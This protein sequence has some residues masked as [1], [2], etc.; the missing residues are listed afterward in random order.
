MAFQS[1]LPARG[2]TLFSI[3]FVGISAFQST[4][5]A[6]GATVKSVGNPSH[7][8][9]QS[10]LP[11]RG[12]TPHG[13]R[14]SNHPCYFNPRS[15]HG[16]RRCRGIRKAGNQAFQSTLPARGA[17]NPLQA[18]D[19]CQRFQSTLPA[20]GATRITLSYQSEK[21]FQSTL[22][23][24]GA[25]RAS[26]ATTTDRDNFNPRSPHGERHKSNRYQPPAD[27]HF[28]PRSP[29][30]ERRRAFC[31][32]ACLR[33]FQ[34][35]LPAR[36]A[37]MKILLMETHKGFQSTLPARGATRGT[38]SCGC[39]RIISIHAPRTGSDARLVWSSSTSRNFNPRSP[40]GERLPRFRKRQVL[41]NFN[42]RS[43][44]GERQYHRRNRPG[45]QISIH[46][47]RTGSDKARAQAPSP[48]RTFQ[49]TLPARGA[50]LTLDVRVAGNEHFN[51]RSPHGERLP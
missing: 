29:H 26:A 12:A 9:F 4:L 38:V 23:A 21:R 47:P 39:N 49:S 5:P 45:Q 6:R 46:A 41:R 31:R 13:K 27:A 17:T 15:P 3:V 16:E 1:T 10:T 33:Q 18:A 8:I 20:R 30:G 36:G 37:T 44:H 22:P 7:T 43:P 48:V 19:D 40:H 35:T 25:T 34:S 50:T 32:S 24:R 51:P 42:P 11:A 2:A 28:N 14:R